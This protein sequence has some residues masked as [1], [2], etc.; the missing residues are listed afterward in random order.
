MKG[1]VVPYVQAGAC[2]VEKRTRLFLVHK[3]LKEAVVKEVCVKECEVLS[4]KV[5]DD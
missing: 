4:E 3:S 2:I 1:G 5:A